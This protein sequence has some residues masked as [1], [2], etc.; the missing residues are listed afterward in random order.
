MNKK[1]IIIAIIVVLIPIT[2]VV[3]LLFFNIGKTPVPTIEQSFKIGKLT[4][5]KNYK[6]ID[7]LTVEAIGDF[8]ITYT[9]VISRSDYMKLD[10]EI[11]KKPYFIEYDSTAIPKGAYD[12]D[13]DWSKINEVAYSINGNT[14]YERFDPHL[15]EDIGIALK[16]DTLLYVGYQNI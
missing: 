7:T 12:T 6:I 3:L 15:G 2:L 1:S 11:R 9:L 14:Y 13:T 4:P 8:L 10:S 16:K 5:I